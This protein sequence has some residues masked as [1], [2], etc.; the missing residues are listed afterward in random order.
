MVLLIN[1]NKIKTTF[2]HLMSDYVGMEGIERWYEYQEDFEWKTM[3]SIN[4]YEDP[5]NDWEGDYWLFQY[6]EEFEGNSDPKIF[7]RLFFDSY[8][9]GN[10]KSMFGN[11]FDELMESW[12]EE[13][14]N[15]PVVSV[16]IG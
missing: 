13:N 7:P 6:Q 9:F 4:F 12:F 8:E 1:E 3:E 5:E 11:L 2:N 14:Y 10:L 16:V 15:L